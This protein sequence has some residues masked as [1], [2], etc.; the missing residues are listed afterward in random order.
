MSDYIPRNPRDFMRHENARLKE[1]NEGLKSE[2]NSLRTFVASLDYLYN[3]T[4][5]FKD[6][7]ELFPFLRNMLTNAMKLLNAPDGSLAL[8]DEEKDELEFVIVIGTLA[9]KLTGQRISAK[10]GIAGWV[11]QKSRPALVRDVR[12]DSRFF[13]GVDEAYSFHTQSIAAAPLVGNRKTYG[14]IEVLNQPGDKPFSEQDLA[15]LKLMCRVAGEA[16]ATIDR[17]PQEG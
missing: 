8:L 5:N 11:T 15:L 16:L 12:R 6:D 14:L 10:K 7:R 2:V 4:D 1:E 3:A 13:T 9:D 17:I